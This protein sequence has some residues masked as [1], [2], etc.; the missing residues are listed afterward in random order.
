M[1]ELD[2]RADDDTSFRYAQGTNLP[3]RR[4]VYADAV[5]RLA[6]GIYSQ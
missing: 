1:T 6:P 3:A 4:T 2:R 5:H